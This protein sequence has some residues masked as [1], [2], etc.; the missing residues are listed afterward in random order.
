MAAGEDRFRWT[1][2]VL[3]QLSPITE[4]R[5]ENR[6]EPARP[7]GGMRR[8]EALVHDL[9]L[10]PRA[11]TSSFNNRHRT[12][13]GIAAEDST[14]DFRL[15][16][17]DDEP[18]VAHPIPGGGTPPI[19]IPFLFEAAILSRIRSPMTS[20]SNCAKDDRMFSVRCPIEVVV[21]NCCVTETKDAPRAS[22]I[23]TILAKS[24]S[25]RVS[26]SIL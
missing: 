7:A 19:H 4:G 1:V 11:S 23:S 24:V 21:L 3:G 5:A 26:R 10:I 9:L 15:A 12:E 2:A 18:P 22:R 20:R 14:H 17:D 25:E 16:I 6:V 13:F 8:P